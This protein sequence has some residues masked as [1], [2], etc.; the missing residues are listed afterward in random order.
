MV[1][2]L[3]QVESC[4]SIYAPINTSDLGIPLGLYYT[5][6]PFFHASTVDGS[7]TSECTFGIPLM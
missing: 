7:V 1:I 2:D 5:D 6:G 4:P 3:F